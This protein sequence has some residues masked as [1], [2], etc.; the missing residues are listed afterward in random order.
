MELGLAFFAVAIPA[1]LLAGISKGGFGSGGAFV[2][3]P[4]LALVI[5]PAVA[6]ATMLPLLMLMD[7]TG[8]RSYWRGWD[9]SRARVLMAGR[10]PGVLLGWAVFRAVDDDGVRLM[11]GLVALGFVAFQLARARGWLRPGQR[12]GGPVSGLLWGGAS[13]FTS[14]V[15]H[16]GGPPASMYLLAS[17]LE[18]TRYQATTVLTFWWANLIKLPAYFALGLISAETALA[19]IALAPVAVAGVLIGVW[20]HVRVP[21]AYFFRIMYALLTVAGARLV[22]DALT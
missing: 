19:G 12:L 5:E 20:A 14:F 17:N 18:K 11:V 21:E 9:W 1:V 15:S 8:L 16:A 22:Y 3:T 2:A 4:L 6:V 10:V 13:E 7:V